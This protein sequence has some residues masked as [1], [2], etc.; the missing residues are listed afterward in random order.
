LA[1]WD[2]TG[3]RMF[4]C[5]YLSLVGEAHWRAGRLEDALRLLDRALVFGDSVDEHFR[6]AELHRLRGEVVAALFPEQLADAERSMR[7]AIA[8][9]HAQGARTLEERAW[10]SLSRLPAVESLKATTRF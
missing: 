8:I 4:R 7:Q 2:D 9:A 1:L 5:L 6:D 3:A 10:A